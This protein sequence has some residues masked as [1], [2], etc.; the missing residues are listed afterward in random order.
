VHECAGIGTRV[1]LSPSPSHKHTLC[2][3]AP[4]LLGGTAAVTSSPGHW[5]HVHYQGEVAESRAFCFRAR[6]AAAWSAVPTQATAHYLSARVC[7]CMCTCMY[8]H[9][10]MGERELST[11][12]ERELS[13]HTDRES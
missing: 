6:D 3:Q 9:V 2:G 10:C 4:V 12:T 13:T 8:A 11:H 5:T 7:V 1:P